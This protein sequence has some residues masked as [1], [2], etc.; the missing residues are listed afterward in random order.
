MNPPLFMPLTM[1]RLIGL[2]RERLR[3]NMQVTDANHHHE[4]P[5][6]PPDSGSGGEQGS[7]NPISGL[8]GDGGGSPGETL[9]TSSPTI[10]GDGERK[11]TA[12]EKLE[13]FPVTTSSIP[14]LEGVD[15]DAEGADA[16]FLDELILLASNNPIWMVELKRYL[17]EEE[18]EKKQVQE[19]RA[20]RLAR[21][22]E[23]IPN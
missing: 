18:K 4:Q 1:L 9:A 21:W 14:I 22:R 7:G 3:S 2:Y 20:A 23:G 19:E 11:Q 17:E 12:E 16:T 13:E 10:V 5:H 15:E 8:M 6:P